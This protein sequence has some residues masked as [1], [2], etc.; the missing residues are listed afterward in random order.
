M[1]KAKIVKTQKSIQE[2]KVNDIDESY[3]LKKFIFIILILVLVFAIF[4]FITILVV[5]PSKEQNLSNNT[6]SQID[7]SKILIGQLL[8]RN[9]NEYYA[10][11]IKPSLYND[12]SSKIDYVQIY[13]KYIGDYKSRDNSLKF[14]TIDLDDALNKNYLS[15][16]TNITDNLSELSISD[17]ALF[18]VNNGKI[19]KYYVGSESII[20]ALSQLK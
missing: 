10:L 13:N 19:E 1:K 20:N 12:Y 9:E 14:Y 8:D 15:D 16:K 18:K 7:T 2:S 6:S 11:A 5:R 4:Y 17:E 3:S